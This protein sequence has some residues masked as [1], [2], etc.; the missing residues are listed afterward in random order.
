MNKVI[1][2]ACTL[3]AMASG[4]TWGGCQKDSFSVSMEFP[5]GSFAAARGNSATSNPTDVTKKMQ[6]IPGISEAVARKRAEV[7]LTDISI[8]QHN[9][10]IS[11]TELNLKSTNVG[12]VYHIQHWCLDDVALNKQTP[13]AIGYPLREE[14]IPTIWVKKSS[15]K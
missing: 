11:L 8:F 3:L 7:L 12:H 10:S 2:L 1:Y 13:R 5:D 9:P 14:T 15:S 6:K 4:Q